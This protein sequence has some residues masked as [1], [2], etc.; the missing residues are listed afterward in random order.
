MSVCLDSSWIVNIP[1]A[2][3][4]NYHALHIIISYISH[5]K[6]ESTIKMPDR[7]GAD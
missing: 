5:M 3:I 6:H 2:R 4:R 7:F 1:R